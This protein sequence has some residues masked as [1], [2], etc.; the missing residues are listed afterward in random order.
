MSGSF[1]PSSRWRGEGDYDAALWMELWA[2]ALRDPELAA[3][4]A[5]LDARWRRTIAEVVRYGQGRGEFGPA[6]PDEFAVLL[7][8]LLD[9]LA[10]QIA[11]ERHGG[12]TGSSA[13]V[14]REIGRARAR[15]RNAGGDEML[16]DGRIDRRELL[17]SGAGLA[18]G[19]G[20]AGCGVGDSGGGSKEATEKPI[21]E[22]VDGDLVYFNWSEYIDP[23]LI[24]RFEKQYGVTRAASRT[25]TRCRR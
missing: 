24:K 8:A 17:R 20:L 4:R 9:G 12:H 25:S 18:L 21:K 7:G 14:G 23:A 19:M 2:R 1:T 13:G 22:K 10:V 3:T 5:D 15:L 16:I 6:D 11:L